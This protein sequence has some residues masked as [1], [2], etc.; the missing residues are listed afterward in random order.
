MFAVLLLLWSL[1]AHA[2]DPVPGTPV[3]VPVAADAPSLVEG[4]PVDGPAPAGPVHTDE[5]PA[6]ETMA[7]ATLT[8]PV[9]DAQAVDAAKQGVDYFHAGQYALGFALLVLLVGYF[10]KKYL[11]KPK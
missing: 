8:E 7:P 11:P 4:P 10:V 9:T 2:E 1:P 6:A 3:P 5:P